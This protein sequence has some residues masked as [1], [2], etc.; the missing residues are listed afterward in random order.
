MN[1]K[2]L[3]NMTVIR[4]LLAVTFGLVLIMFAYNIILRMI[5]F[6]SGMAL[7]YYGFKTLELPALKTFFATMQTQI[8]KFFS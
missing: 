3:P 8:R 2:E 6:V 7:L 1:G 4:G 5:F